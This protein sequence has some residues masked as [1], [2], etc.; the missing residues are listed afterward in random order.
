M[1][2]IL[3]PLES[4]VPW[5]QISLCILTKSEASSRCFSCFKWACCIDFCF[6]LTFYVNMR[7]CVVEQVPGL[8]LYK[9]E[10]IAMLNLPVIHF[11]LKDF[12][13]TCTGEN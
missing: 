5:K 13:G 8:T 12:K 10:E 1:A 6:F 2:N 4:S 11:S 3:S 9:N 7:I